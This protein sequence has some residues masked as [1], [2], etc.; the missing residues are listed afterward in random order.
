MLPGITCPSCDSEYVTRN[1]HTHTGK[2]NH[3]CKD[4]GRNFV[5]GPN[6]K[7]VS[8]DMKR[9]IQRALLERNSLR[10]IA[11]IFEVSMSWLMDYVNT[12]LENVPEDLNIWQPPETSSERGCFPLFD[13][14]CEADE[15]WSFVGN[16]DNKQWVWLVIERET[17]MI[18]GYHVG[19]RTAKDA[20]RLWDSIPDVYKQRG[21]FFT[22]FLA[23]YK[24]ALPADQHSAVGKDS[25]QTN[26]IERFN[27]TCRQRI[28]RLVRSSLGFSRL[29]SNHINAIRYFIRDYNSSCIAKMST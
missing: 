11:R 7:T 8:D 27:N 28:G 3:I 21:F 18:V 6:K 1:G 24:C 14:T 9:F 4:C 23:S 2:Q 15:L 26:H 20:K 29:L 16:K 25:G 13:I 17:R 12:F 5:L 19:G 10:G 22:D